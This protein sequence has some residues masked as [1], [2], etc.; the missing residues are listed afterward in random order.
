MNGDI[1]FIERITYK[2]NKFHNLIVKYDNIKVEYNFEELEDITLAYAISVHK[3]QGSEFDIVIMPITSKHFIMLKRKLI[4]T[5]ITRAKKTLMLIGDVSTLR[6]GIYQFEL[7]RKTILKNK[8][9]ELLHT[10]ND[11]LDTKEISLQIDDEES[12]FDTIGEKELGTF[13]FDDFENDKK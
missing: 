13:T 10:N 6:K 1:G 7:S 9:I 8:I 2:D 5:A 3:A 4:Y 11:E 12:A